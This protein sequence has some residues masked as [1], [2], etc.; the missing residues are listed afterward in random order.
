MQYLLHYGIAG[1]SGAGEPATHEDEQALYEHAQVHGIG[2]GS[3]G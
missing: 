1:S 3:A 2:E